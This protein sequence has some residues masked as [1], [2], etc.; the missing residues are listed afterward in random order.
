M[1]STWITT[2]IAGACTLFVYLI[3]IPLGGALI[4][5]GPN[6]LRHHR[7]L[8]AV[9]GWMV[10]IGCSIPFVILFVA[11]I[12]STRWIRGSVTRCPGRHCAAYGGALAV[13]RVND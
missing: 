6:G 12:P 1:Q 5:T 7:A 9:L 10:G 4:V 8:N 11:F 2:I 13:R 3:G